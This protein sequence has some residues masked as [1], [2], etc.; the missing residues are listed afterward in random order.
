[1]YEI[2]LHILMKLA[3]RYHKDSLE[4]YTKQNSFPPNLFDND[5]A[6]NANG[7]LTSS[8]ILRLLKTYK[9]N[10]HLYE[11]PL[12]LQML[13]SLQDKCE[14]LRD[15]FYNNT[16]NLGPEI[17]LKNF[18]TANYLQPDPPSGIKSATVAP[19]T[20]GVKIDIHHLTIGDL[21]T[22]TG[23]L[24]T[25]AR[26]FRAVLVIPDTGSQT[27]AI[28]LETLIAAG[29]NTAD[30]Q[31]SM[32][33]RVSTATDTSTC[34]PG[35]IE[36]PIF[37]LN[38]DKKFYSIKVKMVVLQTN[39]LVDKIL[40][41]IDALRSAKFSWQSSLAKETLILEV[42]NKYNKV[43]R[44]SF[45][46]ARQDQTY[47]IP[48]AK[49]TELLGDP[50]ILSA[51]MATYTTAF[52]PPASLF[53]IQLDQSWSLLNKDDLKYHHSVTKQND[54]PTNYKCDVHLHLTS[55]T[56]QTP[57]GYITIKSVDTL[58]SQPNEE[59]S[60]FINIF[61]NILTGDYKDDFDATFTDKIQLNPDYFEYE[62]LE[63]ALPDLS[64]LS[65]EL[66]TKY[67]NLF[68]QHSEVC[69][70]STYD[71]GE[72]RLPPININYDK[73]RKAY[74]K[75]RPVSAEDQ[76]LIDEYVSELLQHG[77]IEPSTQPI[78]S[79]HNIRII[80]K[81][82]EIGRPT[83]GKFDKMSKQELNDALK[84]S[85]GRMIAD[86]RTQNELVLD[87][88]VTYL[89]PFSSILPHFSA[90]YISSFDVRS[91]FWTRKVTP[92]TRKLFSFFVAGAHCAHFQWTS[93]PMG[94]KASSPI[95]YKTITYI[96]NQRTLDN[97]QAEFQIECL[98]NLRFSEHVKIYSDEVAAFSNIEEIHYHLCKYI[99]VLLGRYGLKIKSSKC[100]VLKKSFTFLGYNID[101]ETDTYKIPAARSQAILS[102]KFPHRQSTRNVLNSN[103]A[104]I[105]YF[106]NQ[107]YSMKQVACSLFTL[108]RS[109][110]TDI[111]IYK[112][113]KLEFVALQF[114]I[115]LSIEF[116]IPNFNKSFIGFVDASLSAAGGILAQYHPLQ[117]SQ[118]L[119]L[120]KK[121][122]QEVEN[123]IS[124]AG[125]V[126]RDPR[127]Q[128][129]MVACFS[130]FFQRS[131]LLKSIP[132]K[133]AFA[134]SFFLNLYEEYLL[135]CRKQCI[136]FT[137]CSSLALITKLMHSNTR[138][139]S[140]SIHLS[141]FSNLTLIHS[142]SGNLTNS[143]DI[144]SRSLAGKELQGSFAFSSATLE[145]IPSLP[146]KEHEIFK[147]EM[148]YK[149]MTSDIPSL[150]TKIAPR[151][152]QTPSWL[153]Q[154]NL[155]ELLL[156]GSHENKI[157]NSIFAVKHLG[158][159]GFRNTPPYTIKGK[160][161]SP[162][163]FDKHAKKE[164]Y[165]LIHSLLSYIKI[166]SFHIET[167]QEVSKEA[168][169]FCQTLIEFLELEEISEPQ[170]Y[171]ALSHFLE[172]KN[173]DKLQFL[174]ILD[175]YYSSSALQNTMGPPQPAVLEQ[176]T[177]IPAKLA[178]H[179]Q[180][181]LR[182]AEGE[183]ILLTKNDHILKPGGTIVLRTDIMFLSKHF[184]TFKLYLP[185]CEF[186][187]LEENDN[188]YSK[189]SNL[190]IFNLGCREIR[191]NNKTE[192]G[193]FYPNLEPGCPCSEQ[194]HVE[195]LVTVGDFQMSSP[196][197][198]LRTL[199]HLVFQ[200]PLSLLLSDSDRLQEYQIF[201]S[202]YKAI[203]DITHQDTLPPP[204]SV[205]S[206]TLP[207]SIYNLYINR[208]LLLS[209]ILSNEK[210]IS[211]QFILEMQS[212]DKKINN[213]RN[214][215]KDKK[216]NQ[217][218]L[219]KDILF[220][221]KMFYGTAAHLLVVSEHIIYYLAQSLHL[222][223]YHFNNATMTAHLQ[224][225][226][227]CFQMK[228][229]VATA[230][231]GCVGCSFN[232]KARKKKF[233]NI[234]DTYNLVPGELFV[235]D[236]I[237]GMPGS[238]SYLLLMSDYVTN[239]ILAEP[240]R[241][242]TAAAVTHIVEKFFAVTGPCKIIRTDFAPEF[243]SGTFNNFLQKYRVQH[244][245]SC[246]GRHQSQGQIERTNFLFR[247]LLTTM[248]VNAPAETRKNW[249]SLI[250]QAVMVYNSSILYPDVT[251][252]ITRSNL[253][254]THLKYQHSPLLSYLP[255]LSGDDRFKL[256]QQ[257]VE[258]IKKHR[259]KRQT[260]YKS[261]NN[262]FLPGQL[263][264]V[265]LNKLDHPV[266]D[267]GV[268][269]LQPNSVNIYQV[270]EVSHNNC[271]LLDL[272]LNLE[273]TKDIGELE[274]LN[275]S[276]LYGNL[277]FNFLEPGSFTKNIYKPPKHSPLLRLFTEDE[278]ALLPGSNTTPGLG[279]TPA[280]PPPADLPESPVQQATSNTHITEG[281]QIIR[282]LRSRDIQ[283]NN[284]QFHSDRPS[285]IT[286]SKVVSV[287]EIIFDQHS[288]HT[289]ISNYTLPLSTSALQPVF[290]E[291]ANGFAPH[292]SFRCFLLRQT[293]QLKLLFAEI[294]EK[295]QSL[296]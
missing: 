211:R 288:N 146:F 104:V 77:L 274:P 269:S 69:S 97:Y 174:A 14:N 51:Y 110:E 253:F 27:S 178:N 293:A 44:R 15:K 85:R 132:A 46:P 73:T 83:G 186:Y 272:T 5:K 166:H 236:L 35:I 121:E 32:K 93:L 251:C 40:I 144:L 124:P 169:L 34:S 122:R 210:Q 176:F 31:K 3:G 20:T 196:D 283:L 111:K 243:R 2:I 213:L 268:R 9:S 6:H 65:P 248:L 61:N 18:D 4:F 84:T 105:S 89:E 126:E 157:L 267:D 181:F 117:P 204:D 100:H 41:G 160:K 94:C 266:L 252:P 282:R 158:E 258:K 62:D 138:F 270:L 207:N 154:I 175:L 179:S 162:S 145:N 21:P 276:L 191:L 292:L 63:K 140:I 127:T 245:N 75:Y 113:M 278:P 250:P 254:F 240:L 182:P 165:D 28:N 95:W 279:E 58:D 148:I 296:K 249:S 289:E 78:E 172:T 96:L 33:I 184:L 70:L 7:Y 29:Y 230:F 142:S 290:V 164:K 215:V 170:L 233:I 134:L 57:P 68:L 177:F 82:D 217:F 264:Q 152:Q 25:K 257:A 11:V 48:Q 53:N 60:E 286:F 153:D 1:M 225:N 67:R 188:I 71:I 76:L 66:Q 261:Y 185:N 19:N 235:V 37:L 238:F 295:C 13:D 205:Q 143:A 262:P 98:K 86:L 136:I 281:E 222:Q 221:S 47:I 234:P 141:K 220:K 24:P 168:E 52:F 202:D 271:R 115:S 16:Q 263:C 64:H 74:D 72:A 114:L 224:K 209:S 43:L 229:A 23:L 151:R 159:Q 277:G 244:E 56:A 81:S 194:S 228:K 285:K 102:Y 265:K 59:E 163:Q 129:K 206:T 180:V 187:F 54:W 125:Y 10:P 17:T 49:Q 123:N 80:A 247:N 139:H 149:L 119:P 201:L 294:L 189:F 26:D 36:L 246:P 216:T 192:I 208:T 8:N 280:S 242:N 128:L 198:S 171:D 231:H 107:V 173:K 218:I 99:F 131:D 137:D 87:E 183:I 106:S 79:N 259:L 45:N 109:K 120:T 239:F 273:T 226:F 88:E 91:A 223:N 275:P 42:K 291:T 39:N 199:F 101:K 214:Q 260:Y 55:P 22:L 133:E 284:I 12:D 135:S 108:L 161:M 118:P 195:F 287:R 193:K 30:L 156:Q 219:I 130:K 232:L 90:R 197:S 92:Q 112:F 155:D 167:F 237:A 200:E 38:S 150:Y 50:D 190:G 116:T 227:F 241:R 147:P 203:T 256:Q 103:L 255:E 212:S